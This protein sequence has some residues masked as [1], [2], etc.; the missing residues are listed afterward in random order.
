MTPPPHLKAQTP[1]NPK[2]PPPRVMTVTHSHTLS[3][4]SGREADDTSGTRFLFCCWH[5]QRAWKGH[6]SS[7]PQE[8]R[9]TVQQCLKNI[10]NERE[11]ANCEQLLQTL[12]E[13]LEAAGDSTLGFR[14]YFSDEWLTSTQ[15][16]LAMGID[17]FARWA[18]F[19]RPKGTVINTTMK[20][21]RFNKTLKESFLKRHT[22]SRLDFLIFTF[23]RLSKWFW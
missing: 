6:A 8:L 12:F 17:R 23:R 3:I 14:H 7:L 20:K 21:E 15:N 5:V 2:F 9:A 16:E 22:N 18:G 1:L 11:R 19:G 4:C 13:L 10:C